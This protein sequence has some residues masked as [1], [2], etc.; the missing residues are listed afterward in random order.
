MPERISFTKRVIEGLPLPSAG[1]RAYY[2]DTKVNGLLVCVTSHG[3]KS[4]QAY[5]K[6]N[7]K[8]VRV[9]LGHFP[10]MTIEQAR[11][12]A[13]AALSKMAEGINP[14]AEKKAAKV[15]AVTLGDAFK[16]YL[17]SHD[18]KPRTIQDYQAIMKE[19]FPD[20]QDKAIVGITR[21]MVERRHAKLGTR[22]HARANNA[23]RVLRAILN[24]TAGKYEDESGK[25]IILDNPVKRLSSTRSWYRVERRRTLIKP[26]QL[27]AWFNAVMALASDRSTE[28]AEVVRDY[29][30][31]LLLTGLR[32]E[33]AARLR[34]ENIDVDNRAF[35]VPD[36]KNRQA[37]ELP[38]SDFLVE[39]LTRRKRESG[40]SVFVF[41]GEGDTGHLVDPRKQMAKVS[42]ASGV[43]FTL[44]DLRRTFIIIAESLDIPAY[45]LKRLLNHKPGADVTA[46]YIVIDVERLRGP[47]QK[48][49]DFILKA[50]GRKPTAEVVDLNQAR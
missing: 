17:K 47:M 3:I 11:R 13:Q 33:E 7:N 28:K 20:W 30:L 37:H 15:R 41:P 5:R 48:I 43:E 42:Q 10:D 23:M 31:F 18:L 46:G 27:G 21:D 38:L 25:P 1:K 8:P 4:F 14:V 40:D 12:G 9:T 34:W 6:V 36:T 16:A 39:L 50:A 24:F 45:A 2:H 49:T 32:R 35:V 44:H 19:A 22:S 26:H 29:L